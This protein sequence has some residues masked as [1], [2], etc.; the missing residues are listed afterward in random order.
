MRLINRIYTRHTRINLFRMGPLY[1]FSGLTAL[2]AVGLTVPPYGF[3]A[4]NQEILYDPRAV[5]V[6]FLITVLAVVTF[7]WPL[8]G[9]HRLLVKEKERLL[10]EGSR[11]LEATIVELHQRVDSAELEGMMDLNM[12][13]A[14]LEM[15]QQALS[16]TPTWPWQPETLRLFVTALVLPL[17]LL[18][19]QIALQF[20]A[21]R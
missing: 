12:A 11:R 18:V 4:I 20:F 17:V 1:A 7:A 10:E 2:M 21:G 15:E 6:V 9:I 8:L 16:R 13:I 5:G 19:A 3:M 14:S